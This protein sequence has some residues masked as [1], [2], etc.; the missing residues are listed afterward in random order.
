MKKIYALIALSTVMIMAPR[1]AFA[2]AKEEV[3]GLFTE[4]ELPD[5]LVSDL[6]G[7]QVKIGDYAKK[8]KITVINF[9]ATWCGPCKLELNNIAD[10]YNDWQ[11]DYDVQIIAVSIDDSRNIAKVKSYANGRNWTYTVLID[12]NQDLKR[13]INFQ[14]PPFTLILDKSG[15]IVASHTGYKE[16][17]EYIL[18][19]QLKALAKK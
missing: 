15:N 4:K 3:K 9:W 17:D 5:V 18:E 6:D 8:G 2:Q 11:K 12:A 10:L 13:A 1:L 14:A 7:K 16:G 19:D